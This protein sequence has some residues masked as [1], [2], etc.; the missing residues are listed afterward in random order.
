MRRATRVLKWIAIVAAVA[1]TVLLLVNAYFVWSTGTR[2]EA[3]LLAI[4][5][6]GEPVQLSDLAHEPLAPDKNA[7]AFLR[8]IASDVDAIQKE[9]GALF[10]KRG[11]PGGMITPAEQAKL[12]KLFAAFPDMIQTLEQA[13]D[14]PDSDPQFDYT[15]P[16]SRFLQPFMDH[17]GRRRAISRILQTRSVLLRSKRSLDDALGSQILMLR[18]ARHWRREPFIIGY[19]ITAVCEQ[20]AM[21]G[22]NDVLQA[23]PVSASSRQALDHELA[24]HDTTEGYTWALKSERAFALASTWE[25]PG[26]QLWLTRGFVN[27]LLL[28]HIALFDR[29]LERATQPF[30]GAVSTGRS[31]GNSGIDVN[32]LATIAKLLEPALNAAREP[33]DRT[34]AISRSLR[35]LSALQSRSA[36]GNADEPNIAAL[37]VP[38]SATVDPFNGEPLR[39]KKLP[40]GWIV[41]SVGGNLIDD[42]GNLEG[43]ADVGVGP[44]HV[45]GSL[46]VD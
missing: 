34:R 30:N 4:R 20:T 8:R 11:F 7:D 27:D 23:G 19:L 6:A 18:L 29:H 43:R 24:A 39:I 16:P 37:G 22:I 33:A 2:L 46:E 14:A 15:L 38:A 3:R 9:L 28:K 5:Q 10:P 42:G 12:E 41:Y 35:V 21:N 13:A 32:P 44:A 17:I 26:A 40:E 1:I 36:G 25:I 31:A 45:R